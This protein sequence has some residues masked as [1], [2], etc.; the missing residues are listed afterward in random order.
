[1]E[2]Y[3]IKRCVINGNGKTGIL[4]VFANNADE[5]VQKAQES[6]R[7]VL[8]AALGQKAAQ[9]VLDSTIYSY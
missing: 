7:T 1:M 3:K 5:A 4:H 2:N 6:D 9:K 8:T